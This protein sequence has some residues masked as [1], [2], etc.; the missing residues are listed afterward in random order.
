M[1]RLVEALTKKYRFMNLK[2][3]TPE[4]TRASS[5]AKA[6]ILQ[7]RMNNYHQPK[8]S[9]LSFLKNCQ[10]NGNY[11]QQIPKEN[12][13]NYQYNKKTTKHSTPNANTNLWEELKPIMANINHLG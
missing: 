1:R 5:W 12:T 9:I 7:L 10:M 11:T 3:T 2:R 6:E 8:E 13:H 4:F